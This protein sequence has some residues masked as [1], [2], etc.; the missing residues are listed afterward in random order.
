MKVGPALAL[1]L[2]TAALSAHAADEALA[3]IEWLQEADSQC[4]QQG[5]VLR[6]LRNR[7]RARTVRVW[8]DRWYMDVRTADRGKHVLK[9][10]EE[11]WLGCTETRQGPQRWEAIEARFIDTP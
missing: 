8:I 5:G 4:V 9:P 2:C 10:G 6:G 3:A 7:D 11:R 1:L